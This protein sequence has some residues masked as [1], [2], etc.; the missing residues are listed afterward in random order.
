MITNI[1]YIK[2]ILEVSNF[3]LE[4]NINAPNNLIIS[5]NLKYLF[6]SDYKNSFVYNIEKN[7]IL[8]YMKDI[9]EDTDYREIFFTSDFENIFFIGAELTLISIN[10]FTKEI[11]YLKQNFVEILDITKYTN[12]LILIYLEENYRDNAGNYLYS[13]E[14]VNLYKCSNLELFK[15]TILHEC[16]T[17]KFINKDTGIFSSHGNGFNIYNIKEDK[18]NIINIR[19]YDY[20]DDYY[21]N[22][23]DLVV[24]PYL[25]NEKIT[26]EQIIE[27]LKKIELDYST[28]EFLFFDDKI[29]ITFEHCPAIKVIDIN[30]KKVKYLNCFEPFAYANGFYT[31]S[32]NIIMN[33]KILLV[34]AYYFPSNY[35]L[36]FDLTTD[37]RIETFKCNNQRAY[38]P[39]HSNFFVYVDENNNLV[40]VEFYD[41]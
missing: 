13:N 32:L 27:D 34:F 39:E 24:S 23:S 19:K 9:Y 6:Y 8:F 30:T 4:K 31:Y 41:V 11:K 14:S 16:P 35:I 7:E 38:I 15:E 3:F 10:I 29:Y 36:I 5:Q 1:K 25:S 21:F 2:E 12:D 33:G 18:N 17:P 22:Y 20:D 26:K 37:E 28:R 40:K